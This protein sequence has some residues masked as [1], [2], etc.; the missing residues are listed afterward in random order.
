VGVE[1]VGTLDVAYLP[2]S[3]DPRLSLGYTVNGVRVSKSLKPQTWASNHTQLAG[4][5]DGS[6]TGSAA[7]TN[8]CAI[9]LGRFFPSVPL[10]FDLT[11]ISASAVTIGWS[12]GSESCVVEGAYAQR[13]QTASLSGRLS[14]GVGTTRAEVAR[15]ELG[16]IVVTTNG[17]SADASISAGQCQFF[18]RI[19]GVR[20]HD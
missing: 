18:G 10:S 12:A 19:G 2:F 7:P 13:G 8:P 14:C 5:Y 3:G 6:V 20:R 15:V 9:D 4:R 16:N 1:T 17:F 11:A